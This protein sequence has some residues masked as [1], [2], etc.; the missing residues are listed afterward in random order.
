MVEMMNP[1]STGF[2]NPVKTSRKTNACQAELQYWRQSI[3]NSRLETAPPPASPQASEM[4][5][6]KKSMNT[7]DTTRGV[8]SF[9]V[10]SV[11]RARM[12]SICSVTT[13]DPSSLA[14]P[15]AL[16]PETISP[17]M[18]GPSSVT[19]PTATSCPMSDSD[20]K[21][22]SVLALFR[23]SEPPMENPVSTTM[24]SEPTPIRPVYFGDMLQQADLI[25]V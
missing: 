24:G 11:P 18:T 9:F 21:R 17:V 5:V 3:P 19:I 2:N 15:E 22:C 6:R 23:A 8:T 25:G 12:A 16:R 14:I 20:P 13:I 10:G 4:M 1:N 7:V